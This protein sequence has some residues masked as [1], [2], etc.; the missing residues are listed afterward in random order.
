MGGWKPNRNLIDYIILKLP[1]TPE[2]PK[3]DYDRPFFLPL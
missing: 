3:P 2:L 1:N